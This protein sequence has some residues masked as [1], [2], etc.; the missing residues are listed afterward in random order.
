[1]TGAELFAE[2]YEKQNGQKMSDEQNAY[3]ESVFAVLREEGTL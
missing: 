3:A 1:M 2:L